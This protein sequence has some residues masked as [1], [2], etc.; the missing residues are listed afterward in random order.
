MKNIQVVFEVCSMYIQ[1]IKLK[2]LEACLEKV[3]RL[4]DTC[5][6]VSNWIRAL[7]NFLSCEEEGEDILMPKIYKYIVRPKRMK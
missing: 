2:I 5:S 1:V 7:L 3:E 4:C 6:D